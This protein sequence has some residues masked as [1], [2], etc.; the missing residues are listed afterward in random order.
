L[1]VRINEGEGVTQR[2]MAHDF[3]SRRGRPRRPRPRTRGAE[4]ANSMSQMTDRSAT[5]YA[6]LVQGDGDDSF[7]LIRSRRNGD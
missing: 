6:S 1:R 7:T 2:K 5:F 4:R 3:A